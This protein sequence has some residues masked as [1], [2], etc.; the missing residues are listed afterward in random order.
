[1]AERT[2]SE[3]DLRN[4]NTE[5]AKELEKQLKENKLLRKE[6]DILKLQMQKVM[7]SLNLRQK[8]DKTE[9]PDDLIIEPSTENN[10]DD[11]DDDDDN[12]TEM[13]EKN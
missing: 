7:K 1:M 12:D 10:D 6:I 9:I 13:W 2:M 4:I 8:S 11:N 5:T 3:E